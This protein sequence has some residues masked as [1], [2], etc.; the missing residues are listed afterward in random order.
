[1]RRILI[2]KELIDP[3]ACSYGF[4]WEH[5]S[6]CF[7]FRMT[8]ECV[9]ADRIDEIE[10]ID[11][12]ETLVIGCDLPDYNFIEGMTGLKQLY[13][14]SGE[15]LYSLDFLKNLNDLRQLYIADSHI[16]SLEPLVDLI[17]ERKRL[18]DSETDISKRLFM[19][20]EGIC[21]VSD[22]ELDEK[23]LKEPGLHISEIIIKRSR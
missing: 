5:D 14:Y 20:M 11:D 23:M 12:I 4:P 13:I 7:N 1:M 10:N 9:T 19:M 16:E 17:K 3:K 15:S 6:T 22:K 8:E 18:Y 21:I 2:E